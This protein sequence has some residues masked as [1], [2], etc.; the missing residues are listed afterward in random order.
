M[1]GTPW[2]AQGLSRT[3]SGQDLDAALGEEAA[4]LSQTGLIGNRD[5][6]AANRSGHREVPLFSWAGKG[7]P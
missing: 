5:Q 3:P 2:I 7:Q 4:E 6:R 1:T